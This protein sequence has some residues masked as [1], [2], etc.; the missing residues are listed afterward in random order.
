[1]FVVVNRIANFLFFSI[2][3]HIINCMHALLPL[4]RIRNFLLSLLPNKQTIRRHQYRHDS[5]S[6]PSL[7]FC[8][9]AISVASKQASPTA[10]ALL[11][12]I[13]SQQ[14]INKMKIYSLS[15]LCAKLVAFRI[16][17]CLHACSRFQIRT[18]SFLAY[19]AKQS[20]TLSLL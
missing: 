3:R 13:D 14:R 4:S 6:S 12:F 11:I 10:A 18:R 1:V 19:I 20:K 15:L 7:V 2:F 8:S 17:S 16:P 9:N 5:S